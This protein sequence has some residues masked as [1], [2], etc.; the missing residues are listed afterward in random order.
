M[1]RI[2]TAREK[3]RSENPSD[4]AVRI[5]FEKVRSSRDTTLAWAGC[6]PWQMGVLVS[7]DWSV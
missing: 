7:E 4:P 3:L 5:D 2:A 1:I 6:E